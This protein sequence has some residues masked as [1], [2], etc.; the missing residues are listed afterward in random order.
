MRKTLFSLFGFMCLV[1][2][3][4]AQISFENTFGISAGP[5]G[6]SG[7]PNYCLYSDPG[8][9]LIVYIYLRDPINHDFDDGQDRAVTSVR[10]FECKLT[11]TGDA[12]V[13]G[14]RF[15]VP[16]IDVGQG[17]N[18]IVGFGV[19]VTVD[20]EGIAVLAEVDVLFNFV[21]GQK[22]APGGE[23]ASPLPCD[24]ATGF[25]WLNPAYPPSIPDHMAYLD[26]DDPDAYDMVAALPMFGSWEWPSFAIQV[27]FVGTETQ[28]WDGVKALYR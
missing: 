13:L 4:G 2:A 9:Q 15:P 22:A 25:L 24:E 1:T 28:S 19:P 27:N 20:P 10:G 11:G 26:A 14:R 16:A 17:S 6:D 23:T 3:A 7:F 5:L 8:Q 12:L 21:P 18:M